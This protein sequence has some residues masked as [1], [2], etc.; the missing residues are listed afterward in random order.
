MELGEVHKLTGAAAA[1]QL[2]LQRLAL[3]P[4]PFCTGGIV[5]RYSSSN[6]NATPAGVGG[7]A[8]H[9]GWCWV[10]AGRGGGR[11]QQ[12]LQQRQQRRQQQPP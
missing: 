3:S 10:E 7:G 1:A 9:G 12:Y 11:Q 6:S 5:G 2:L 4:S 8:R